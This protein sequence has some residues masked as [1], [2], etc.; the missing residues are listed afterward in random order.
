[1][2]DLIDRQAEIDA[3]HAQFR[4]GFDGDKW[5]NSTHVLA[6]IKGLP[7][8]P[9]W[10]PVTEQLPEEG[11]D[12]LCCFR[13]GEDYKIFVSNRRD[14]NYWSGIGRTGDNVAWMPLPEPW[15]GERDATD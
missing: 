10:I 11:I 1:M 12:V 15:K 3:L 9:R 6:V 8:E 5:W 14:Y 2:S 7:S 4:D 13:R